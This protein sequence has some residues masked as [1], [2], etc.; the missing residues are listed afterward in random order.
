[1][2]EEDV[3]NPNLLHKP[4]VEGPALIV[5]GREGQALIFPIVTQVES[6]GEVLQVNTPWFQPQT[7]TQRAPNK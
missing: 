1:M 3:R 5:L 2:D 7:E 6:H 4:G